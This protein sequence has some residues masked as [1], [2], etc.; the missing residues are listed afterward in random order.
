M[1]LIIFNK[2]NSSRHVINVADEFFTTILQPKKA[3]KKEFVEKTKNGGQRLVVKTIIPKITPQSK[4]FDIGIDLY[5]E[6]FR[7]YVLF[8]GDKKFASLDLLKKKSY[9]VK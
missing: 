4:S 6:D 1:Q 7:G 2:R 8:R 5:G 3:Y 9:T